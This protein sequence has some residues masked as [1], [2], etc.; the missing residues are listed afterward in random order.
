MFSSFS[1]SQNLFFWALQSLLPA[2]RS[3]LH[4]PWLRQTVKDA[5]DSFAKQCCSSYPG[6][7]CDK[8]AKLLGF[9][10]K[11]WEERRRGGYV[12]GLS[13]LLFFTWLARIFLWFPGVF[14]WFSV[15]FPRFSR[16]CLR[17]LGT[18][19]VKTVPG[20]RL[21]HVTHR[22]VQADWSYPTSLWFSTQLFPEFSKK[23]TDSLKVWPSKGPWAFAFTIPPFP[24]TTTWE[25]K[26]S[27]R[28][29]EGSFKENILVTVITTQRC[30]TKQ[31]EVIQSTP[32]VWS[33]QSFFCRPSLQ[34]KKWNDLWLMM[35]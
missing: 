3:H 18:V 32:G 20:T 26:R 19:W 29:K 27:G 4:D 24:K 28:T 33:P 2:T 30:Q 8:S 14:R 31:D 10:K 22:Q 6:T 7:V 5:L 17:F 15:V 21:F 11:W 13:F 16:I 9:E 34:T 12:L 25:D 1:S 23:M 35:I